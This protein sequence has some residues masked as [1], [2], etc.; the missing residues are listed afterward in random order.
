MI[1]F[2]FGPFQHRNI[3]NYSAKFCLG[4]VLCFHDV[5]QKTEAYTHP[6]YPAPQ[7]MVDD[8]GGAINFI[9]AF[10]VRS[11]SI[12]LCLVGLKCNRCIRSDF[13]FPAPFFLEFRQMPYKGCQ[14]SSKSLGRKD[15]VN[16]SHCCLSVC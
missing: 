8:V 6:N 11:S 14:P 10:E 13:V 16:D 2:S 7:P 15:I 3:L 12:L 5:L 4:L 9:V 1:D